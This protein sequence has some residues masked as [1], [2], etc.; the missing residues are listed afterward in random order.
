MLSDQAMRV[1][2]HGGISVY[3]FGHLERWPELTQAAFGRGGGVSAPPYDSLN[4]SFAVKDDPVRVRANRALMARTLGWDPERIVSANQVHGRRVEA[5][6]RDRIGGPDLPETDALVT[7]QPGVLLL[8][9]FADCVPVVLWDP[10]RRVVGVA[11][12]GWRGT[13][14]GTPAA[15]LECMRERYHTRASDV[16]VGIGPSIGPCC[17]EVGPEVAAQVGRAFVGANVLQTGAD[18]RMRFDLWS[19]NVE[20]LLRAGVAEEHVAVAGICTRCQH[21]LFFSH[22]AAGGLTGRFAFVAGIRDE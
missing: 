22:R 2:H 1:R 4:A 15:A 6:G 14:A 11:H 7:D 12:A 18:G 10:V 21:D 3:S 16:M 8:L 20:T 19:A 17:Y 9:K 13:V 5:V